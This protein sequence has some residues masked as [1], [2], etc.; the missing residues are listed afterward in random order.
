MTCPRP[1]KPITSTARHASEP[2]TT[3]PTG[4]FP[5]TVTHLPSSSDP[6]FP[7]TR[8]STSNQAW[9]AGILP[10]QEH[11]SLHQQTNSRPDC[12]KALD[13]M[14]RVQ[15]CCPLVGRPHRSQ[16]RFGLINEGVNLLRVVARS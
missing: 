11:D 5:V 12:M 16:P 4:D 3:T 9:T 14:G 10:R 1:G 2:T 7:R 15:S 6:S 13:R 8:N